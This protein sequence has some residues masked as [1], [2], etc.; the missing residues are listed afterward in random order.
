MTLMEDPD[1]G[2]ARRAAEAMSHLR[3]ID[4]ATIRRAGDGMPARGER[5]RG[6]H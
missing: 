1:P 6:R 3:R 5:C 4:L 2:R